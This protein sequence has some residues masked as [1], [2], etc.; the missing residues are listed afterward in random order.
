M[1]SLP[2]S[3][4][5]E[6]R[7]LTRAQAKVIALELYDTDSPAVV[8][9]LVLAGNLDAS[10]LKRYQAEMALE[11]FDPSVDLPETPQAEPP[12]LRAIRWCVYAYDRQAREAAADAAVRHLARW[13]Q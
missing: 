12:A 7:S 1:L 4:P 9:L 13:G 11:W 2:P 8:E 5:S 6:D 3:P 10:T